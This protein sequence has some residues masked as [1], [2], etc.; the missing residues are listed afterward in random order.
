MQLSK[1]IGGKVAR[2]TG[3]VIAFATCAAGLALMPAASA[4]DATKKPT[5][6]TFTK[7][8]DY[9]TG[10]LG[11]DMADHTP[12]LTV[13]KYLSLKQGITPTGSSQ[14]GAELAK[15][16]TPGKEILFELQ[17]IKPDGPISAVDA[18][19]GTGYKVDTGFGVEGSLVGL[20]DNS[21]TITDWRKP[22]ANR[23]PTGDPVDLPKI[24][25]EGTA[26]DTWY[27]PS[28]FILKEDTDNSPA[29]QKGVYDKNSYK[30]AENSLITLPYQTVNVT[31]Y[32]DGTKDSAVV[33]VFH[34]HVFPKNISTKQINKRVT[35]ITGSDGQPK[36]VPVAGDK[37]SYEITQHVT[38]KY[39]GASHTNDNDPELDVGDLDPDNTTTPQLRIVDRMSSALKDMTNV[40]VSLKK[41]DG[42]EIQQLV[43]D[44]DYWFTSSPDVPARI[45]AGGGTMFDAN[46]AGPG[47]MYYVFDFFKNPTSFKGYMNGVTEANIV[48]D[49]TTTVTSSGDSTN[50]APGTLSNSVAVD[51]VGLKGDDGKPT[52]PDHNDT[53]TM[54]A[55]AQFGKVDKGGTPL[56]GAV[57]RLSQGI[58]D[59][60]DMHNTYLATDGKFHPEGNLPAGVSFYEATSTH[61]GIVTFVGLPVFET[62]DGK[63]AVQADLVWNLSEVK[64]PAGFTI[65]DDYFKEAISFKK[66]GGQ[67]V[68][69]LIKQTNSNALSADVTIPKGYNYTGS[70]DGITD[71]QGTAVSQAVI[72]FKPGEPGRPIT[73]PLTGGRGIILLLVVGALIMVGVLYA[74]NRRGSAV[75]AA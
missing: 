11:A 23:L 1:S 59:G 75:H 54:T 52:D 55:G 6:T 39:G 53:K 24:T 5:G 67:T 34:L 9:V 26:P 73:L 40:K 8:D 41:T 14:Q 58:V 22:G 18:Q 35:G 19:A 68:D 36:E 45:Q 16:N 20:T 30:K 46:E 31:S 69:Q 2:V 51:H 48:I 33:N 12:H 42:S 28:Y 72:N 47:T 60:K 10:E 4:D 43:Q 15:D 50:A 57:F 29:F 62:K 27:S 56:E 25:Q 66:V 32:D 44:T 3:V 61:N 21:G 38:N 74:R 71:D 70:L 37:I 65:P 13:V 64:A 17:K 49:F 63:T 7:D